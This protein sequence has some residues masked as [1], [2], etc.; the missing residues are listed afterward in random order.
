MEMD[1]AASFSW[2]RVCHLACRSTITVHQFEISVSCLMQNVV[3]D[4]LVA[5]R[6]KKIRRHPARDRLNEFVR[7]AY[8]SGIV[9]ALHSRIG[10]YGFLWKR[11]L[12]SVEISAKEI[13][14]ECGP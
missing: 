6:T 7:D 9:E 5:E 11:W 2:R 8:A 13:A 4:R 3:Q 1:K 10:E 14:D 12:G